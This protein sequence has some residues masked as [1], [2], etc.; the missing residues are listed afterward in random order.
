MGGFE[1]EIA[2]AIDHNPEKWGGLDGNH[3]SESL[4]MRKREIQ[5]QMKPLFKRKS[6][7]FRYQTIGAEIAALLRDCWGSYSIH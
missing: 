4:R 7:H 5:R 6:T 1:A 3:V 2:V